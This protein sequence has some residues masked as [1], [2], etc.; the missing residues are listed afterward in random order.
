MTVILKYF[1]LIGAIFGFINGFLF[2]KR[3]KKELKSNQ[4]NQHEIDVLAKGYLISMTLPYLILQLLQLVG[5]YK[6]AFFIF[7]FD[8][9][10][11]YYCISISVIAISWILLLYW[12]LIMNG[13][14]IISNYNSCF[15]NLPKSKKL[16]KLLVLLMVLGG[17]IVFIILNRS[18]DFKMAIQMF[19]Q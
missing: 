14:E 13:A 15:R 6:S 4:E 19:E 2:Y 5:G 12:I 10:N 3:I 18:Y 7:L 11:L 8:Y 1:W 17:L 9:T 16:I